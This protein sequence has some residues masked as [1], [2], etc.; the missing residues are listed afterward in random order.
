[1]ISLAEIGPSALCQQVAKS[2]LG[3]LSQPETEKYF[4]VKNDY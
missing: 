3:D 2:W 4:L 1:M